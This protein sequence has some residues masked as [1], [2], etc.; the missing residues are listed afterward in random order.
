VGWGDECEL[1]KMET[2]SKSPYLPGSADVEA[3]VESKNWVTVLKTLLVDA[4]HLHKEDVN[5]Q[6]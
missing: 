1:K 2:I 4:N 3:L 5:N 6:C